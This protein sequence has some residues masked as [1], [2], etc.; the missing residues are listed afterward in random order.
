MK[1]KPLIY[2]D[3]FSGIG[4]FTLGIK[5]VFPKA[6][7]GG[8]SEIEPSAIQVYN[9]HF[10]DHENLG[11]VSKLKIKKLRKI[12]SKI[13]DDYDLMIVGGSPCQNLSNANMSNQD[14]L[15]GDKSIL[16]W[17]FARLVKKLKPKYFLLENVA[18][19][20]T[21]DRD[22]ISRELGVTPVRLD[23]GLVSV[24]HRERLYWCNWKVTPPEDRNLTWNSIRQTKGVAK[25]Y[26]LKDKA[27]D[28]IVEV[29]LNSDTHMNVVKGFKNSSLHAYSRSIRDV[30]DIDDDGNYV[31]DED[32]KKIKIGT[33]D[34]KRF[35][36]DG[37]ANTLVTA[38]GC[39][40]SHS[41]NFVFTNKGWRLITRLEASR[42]QTFPDGWCKSISLSKA[43]KAF[44][45]AVTAEMIEHIMSQHPRAKRK[46]KC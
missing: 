19:M 22:L 43:Y 41:K 36:K 29:A 4:G 33:N 10:P 21:K 20:K 5:R 35:R 32:G 17:E 45:N 15:E 12:L 42:I 31:L 13:A 44:G 30:W 7:C 39:G 34:E 28:F 8:F 2:I 38:R 27:L 23:S 3:L 40:G 18:S 14:G 6:K 1:K 11:D 37:K 9:E 26:Y 24:G 16:F 46:K 25:E